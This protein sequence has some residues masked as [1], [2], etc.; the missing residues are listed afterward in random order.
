M[1]HARTMF[2]FH[3]QYYRSGGIDRWVDS[4]KFAK[5]QIVSG[6]EFKS[7]TFTIKDSNDTKC[8]IEDDKYPVRLL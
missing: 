8:E 7:L 1:Y 3:S 5:S 6:I 4:C 2:M